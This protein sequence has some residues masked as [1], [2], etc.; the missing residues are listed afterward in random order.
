MTNPIQI[1]T[2]VFFVICYKIRVEIKK[3]IPS[4]IIQIVPIRLCELLGNISSIKLYPV[5]TLPPENN[6][7]RKNK[8]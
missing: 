4:V 2:S 1:Q 5:L 3:T 7:P 8:K 6:P